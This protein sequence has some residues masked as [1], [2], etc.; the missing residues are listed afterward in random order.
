M[1]AHLSPELAR[2]ALKVVRRKKIKSIMIFGER[3]KHRIGDEGVEHDRR[4]QNKK[5]LFNN[6]F[7]VQ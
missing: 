4:V 1:C 6:Y 2:L 5:I 3:A 7:Y